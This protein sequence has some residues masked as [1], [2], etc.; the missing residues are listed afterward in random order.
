M[1]GGYIECGS[2]VGGDKSASAIEGVFE[3]IEA[4]LSP[5][6]RE[7]WQRDVVRMIGASSPDEMEFRIEPQVVESLIGPLQRYYEQ[8]GVK[9]GHP[10]PYEAPALDTESGLDPVEAKW[11]AGD[12]WRYYCAHDLLEACKVSLESG[13]E[14]IVTFD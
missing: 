12:G 11:G 3:A 13:E 1:G 10:V 4:M 9:L 7:R 14:V 6:E 8:L 2:F 5:D